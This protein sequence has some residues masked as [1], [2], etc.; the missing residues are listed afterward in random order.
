M[1]LRRF[2]ARHLPCFQQRIAHRS[3]GRSLLRCG[4]SN[5]PMT[6]V[7]QTRSSTHVCVTSGLPLIADMRRTG[8]DVG[9]VPGGDIPDTHS[10]TSSARNRIDVGMSMPMARAVLR[11]TIVV[12]FVARSTGR[13]AGFAPLRIL[14][15]KTAARRSISG[16]FIP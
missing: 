8:L 5:W 13:S 14:S 3:Y 1:N 12:N 4:I 9:F 7:G 10:I 6:A 15:T 2:T 16:K 11:L